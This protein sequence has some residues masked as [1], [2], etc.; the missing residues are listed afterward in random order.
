MSRAN[1][2]TFPVSNAR[3]YPAVIVGRSVEV[4]SPQSAI[5]YS[6]AVD[7]SIGESV[8]VIDAAPA[9][10]RPVG[11][12]IGD[13]VNLIP[14]AVGDPCFIVTIGGAPRLFVVTERVEFR[15]CTE[16]QQ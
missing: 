10:G 6:A 14:C 9:G 7:A 1:F 11:T 8:S 15:V 13:E 12:E 5:T 2:N 16:P 4:P 3:V